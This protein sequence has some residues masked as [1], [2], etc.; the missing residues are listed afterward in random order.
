[1]KIAG[2][3]SCRTM[4]VGRRHRRGMANGGRRHGDRVI[5]DAHLHANLPNCE[6][7]ECGE[8]SGCRS[9]RE[10]KKSHHGPLVLS[11]AR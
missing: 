6:L 2:R 3:G 1:M 10:S 8:E 4:V 9:D 11:V 5:G 7:P